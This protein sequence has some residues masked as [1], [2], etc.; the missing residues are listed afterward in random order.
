MELDT[1]SPLYKEARDYAHKEGWTQAQFTGA[2]GLYLKDRAAEFARYQEFIKNEDEALGENREARKIARDKFIDASAKAWF[3]QGEAETVANIVKATPW[4]RHLFRFFEKASEA[5]SRQGL[6]PY[7]AAGREP[8][9]GRPDGL[10]E[11]W[12][13]LD[14]VTRRE[15]MLKN[16]DWRGGQTARAH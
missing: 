15:W 13:K 9:E 2:L 5:V 11:N 1:A 10:P 7:S 6:R 3:P 4:N 16:P 14:P 8:V 12:D